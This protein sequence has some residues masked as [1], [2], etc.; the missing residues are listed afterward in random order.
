MRVAAILLA[1]GASRRFGPADKLLVEIDGV[2]LVSRTADVL[3]AC[4][5]DPIIAVVAPGNWAV[6]RAL[7][8]TRT[9]RI[10]NPSHTA[11]LGTSIAAGMRALPPD[12]DGVLI[13]PADM[14][15]LMPRL[16]RRIATAFDA[17]GGTHIVHAVDAGGAQRNPV[18]WPRRHFHRLAALDGEAGGKAILAALAD[19][20]T[21]VYADDDHELDDIDTPE[22]LARWNSRHPSPASGQPE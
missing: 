15:S 13:V 10:V 22:D 7:A 21:A 3:V 4:V 2:P 20:T 16:V 19:E 1:A 6:A 5:L 12:I 18:L 9:T 11:G 17:A 8:N 14:P